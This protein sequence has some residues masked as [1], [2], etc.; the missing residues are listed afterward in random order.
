MNEVIV[1]LAL[2]YAIYRDMGYTR[3]Q[4]TQIMEHLTKE[5]GLN[6]RDV[7]FQVERKSR[8]IS[9]ALSAIKVQFNES[10]GIERAAVDTTKL[11]P[12]TAREITKAIEHFNAAARSQSKYVLLPAAGDPGDR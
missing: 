5:H 3:Q 4:T 1:F 11:D 9:E 8:E 7:A 2:G 6:W 12:E 10:G